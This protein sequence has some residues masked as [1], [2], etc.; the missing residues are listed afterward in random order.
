MRGLRR[1]NISDDITAP[2][3]HIWG[4]FLWNPAAES[5]SLFPGVSSL[6]ARDSS[7][8]LHRNPPPFDCIS[9]SAD[10]AVLNRIGLTRLGA[11]YNNVFHV[12]KHVMASLECALVVSSSI[13]PP[14]STNYWREVG[15]ENSCSVRFMG[16]FR[17]GLRWLTSLL[18]KSRSQR[19]AS[20]IP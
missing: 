11:L 13:L 9:V 18:T 7:L 1:R 15:C 4:R 3:A 8:L 2:N 16:R 14:T 19:D 17:P 20:W 6:L 5:S 12:Q 10:L